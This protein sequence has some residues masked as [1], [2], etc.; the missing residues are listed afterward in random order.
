MATITN[1]AISSIQDM[2]K[3]KVSLP[4]TTNPAT[5]P[6][7]TPPNDF[8]ATTGAELTTLPN[9]TLTLPGLNL[10]DKTS[11]VSQLKDMNSKDSALNQQARI[12]AQEKGAASGA[13]HSSQ[14]AGA[15]QRA[16]QDANTP[17]AV[18]EANKNVNQEVSNWTNQTQQALQTYEKQYTERLNKLGYAADKQAF[19]AQTSTTLSNAFLA[20]MTTMM[21]NIDLEVDQPLIDTMT[22]IFNTAMDN[23]N[24]ILD[25]KFTY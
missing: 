2:F 9:P 11:V 16:V 3:N 19:M 13:I 17:L 15:V 23:N 14:Q 10:S 4:S 24:K 21:N 12:S 7:E 1:N 5:T 6:E 18:L 8:N 22:S 25:M 20:S